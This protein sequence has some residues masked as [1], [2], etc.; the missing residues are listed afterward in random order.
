[1]PIHIRIRRSIRIHVRAFV[2]SA[3]GS[4]GKLSIPGDD[5]WP[6]ELRGGRGEEAGE[7]GSV[8]VISF[9]IVYLLNHFS[10]FEP[11]I[12]RK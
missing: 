12:W 11:Q 8:F 9:N 1:M 7:T 10:R 6:S 2:S 3:G 4:P 5:R